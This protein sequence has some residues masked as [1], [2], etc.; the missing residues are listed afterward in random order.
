MKRILLSFLI[1]NASFSIAPQ[2]ATAQNPQLE[3]HWWQ[4]N[5]QVNAI[6]KDGNT[7]YLGGSFTSVNPS[8]PE[9]YGTQIDLT[10][11]FPDFS[12]ANPNGAVYAALPDGSGGWYIGGAFTQVGGVVRNRIA[13]INSDGTLHP[14]NP[15]ANGDVAVL[16]IS[17]TTVYV[18][19]RFTSIGGQ[20][21]NRIAAL[22]AEVDTDN[23]TDWNP[24]SDGDVL[25]L[26]VSGTTI[27]VGGAFYTI[28]GQSRG[29]IAALD[30]ETDT[31]N[32]TA[33]NPNA[34][35]NI[36]ALA[37]SGTTVYAG[38]G[39]T[40]IGGQNR[41]NIAAIRT[42]I[43]TNNATAWNPNPNS[44]VRALA[45][46]GTTLYVG[47]DFTNIGGQGRNRIAALNTEVNTGMATAWNPNSDNTVFSLVVSG[48]TIYVG[49]FFSAIGGQSRNRIAALYTEVNTNNA[50]PWHCNA[51]TVVYSLAISDTKAYVG[52]GFTT[53]GGQFRNRIAAI[54]ATTG[55]LTAWNPNA[56]NIVNT[57][58][59]SGTTVYAGGTFTSI[60]GQTRN[61]IAAID[62]TTGQPTAWDPNAGGNVSA[63][64][65]SGTTVYAGGAF[66]TIGGQT[67]NRIAALNAEAD[68]DNATDWNPNAGGNVNALAV[69]GTTVYAGG[70]FTTIGGQTRNRI[71]ALNAEVNINNATAWNPNANNA[72]NALAVSGT[73]VYAGGGF[74]TIGGQTRNRIAAL[75]AE[76][77]TNN[78]TAWNPN[79]NSTVRALA[80]SG[81][82]VYAGGDFSIIGGQS[83]SYIAALSAAVNTN[84][85][86]AWAPYANNLVFALA[87]SGTTLLSGGSF[88]TIDGQS[89]SSLA[90]FG[91]PEWTGVNGTAW[92]DP[93][94]WSNNAI[95]T[96]S[97]DAM[98]PTAPTGGNMPT[99]NIT[100]AVVNNLEVETGASLT[101]SSGNALT[102][103]GYLANAGT[104]SIEADAT[105]IGSLITQGSIAGAGTFQMEQYLLGAGGATP[106]GVFQYV[107]SPVAGTTSA[108]YDA[109]GANKL[110]S[111]SEA[112]QAYTE[113]MDNATA[114]NVGEGYVARV[115][116]NGTITAQ[117]TAFHTGNVNINTLTRTGTTA[118]NRGYNL[119]G[120]P[121]PSS[122][123]WTTATRNNVETTLW[124]RTHTAGGVMMVE[125]FNATG[126]I[127]TNT[128]NYTGQAAVGIIPPGQAFWVRVVEGET[129]GSVSF[130]NAMRSHGTQA[131]I[132]R[133]E[134]EE[135]TVRLH[136]SNGTVSDETIVHFT[137]DAADSYDDFDSQKM[138]MSGL[139]QLYT[140][141][142]TDS[143]TINGL[144]SIETNPIVDLG[145]KAPSAGDYTITASSITLSE[146]VWLEDRALNNFQH[147][148]QDPVYAFTTSQGN[149]GDRFALHFGMMA[150]GIVRDVACNVCTHVFAADGMVNVSVGNDINSGM[151]TIL[152]MMGR[153][154][155]TAAISGSR[156]VVATDLVTGIYLV[157][158]ETE[159]G[160]ETQRVMLR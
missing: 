145:I 76:V 82:T 159:K 52:G 57:L 2:G 117:G 91:L 85:A 83:R 25:S 8:T 111:A 113:I 96:A 135:G 65:V 158:V 22:D 36:R 116:A 126:G 6:V 5:G 12:F 109:A 103:S 32:A 11:G 140:T 17:G 74:T 133:Q 24:N 152:D 95:P 51:N 59:V 69:S 3:P 137:T 123:N 40:Y 160:A 131:S 86:S 75:N 112:T 107:S 156:T 18:G 114:L 148:N 20:S 14:W 44:F 143:L 49:G 19:G 68:T 100:G 144:F 21:R 138:W 61:R 42:D 105:G 53:I 115:G 1:L 102:I 155:Q 132:Y 110:W 27:Y 10:T 23:A 71:A 130:T 55:Q 104:L 73:T 94:N 147:L 45:I 122:V 15:N 125:T 88:T 72:V 80:V 78:A 66:T 70:A 139:P 4:P 99:V 77:N 33:W 28:G 106:N 79:A 81:T 9:P 50:T 153:T 35:S 84:N 67:R 54:D 46:S 154:V 124:Y 118:T 119:I 92:N 43:N 87:A 149:I 26:A 150:V 157:R 41:N 97:T 93:A 120:N 29:N 60:G 48:T 101:I 108:T 89:R 58:A 151:I 16:A 47:G 31:D 127:G 128:G 134:A 34:N 136:L 90:V 121:Y 7:V 39:F 38:G 56:N 146:E 30:T 129:E 13:R 37:V 98:I 63:L 62:A 64:A 141:V 142:G